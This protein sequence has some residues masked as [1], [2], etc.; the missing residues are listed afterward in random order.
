M[1]NAMLTFARRREA[2]PATPAGR[3]LA[4]PAARAALVALLVAGA[5]AA[6]LL[7]GGP[8]H[9]A[10]AAQAVGV[11]TDG[12]GLGDDEEMAYWQTDP[13]AY[14]TDGDGLGDGAEVYYYGTDPLMPDGPPVAPPPGPPPGPG[15]PNPFCP[16]TVFC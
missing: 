15:G 5:L 11:D 12:D 7:A 4:R 13:F 10:T 14:D 16:P 3:R 6:A 2:A 9:R 8:G 1:E